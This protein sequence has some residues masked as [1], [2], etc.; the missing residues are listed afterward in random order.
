M[1]ELF[2]RC[3]DFLLGLDPVTVF[4]TSVVVFVVFF[5]V[6]IRFDHYHEG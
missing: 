3:T 6:W 4:V 2:S 1:I 5:I